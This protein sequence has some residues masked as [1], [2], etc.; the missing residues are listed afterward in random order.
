MVFESNRDGSVALFWTLADAPGDAEHLMTE[1]SGT[2]TLGANS[3]SRDGQTLAFFRA[4]PPDIGLLSMEGD[5]TVQMLLDT[6]FSEA[7]PAIS[8][9]GNWIAYQSDETRQDEVYVQRFPS[10]GDKIAVSTD[11]GAQP[12]WSPDGDELFYRGPRGMMAVPVETDP[13]FR[14]GEPELLFEQQYYFLLGRRTYDLAPDGRF[15]MVKEETAPDASAGQEVI[16]LVQN[17]FEELTRL[18]PTL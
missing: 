2:V 6:E 8:P 9:D 14:A 12:L 17:W 16:I 11:G 18:V 10:L 3:W 7:A 13:T 5:R 1:S 4:P 15:L